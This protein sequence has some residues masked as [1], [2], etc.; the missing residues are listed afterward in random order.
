M[1]PNAAAIAA[2]LARSGAEPRTPVLTTPTPTDDAM[3]DDAMFSIDKRRW[4]RRSSRR[5]DDITRKK[6]LVRA[7]RDFKFRVLA[8]LELY[9]RAQ[10]G[11]P[12]L[13]GTALP[14]LGAMQTALAAGTPQASA[15]A[16]RIGGVLT[17][18]V[19]H[20]RDLP[21]DA[22]TEPDHRR[23]RCRPR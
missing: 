12:W 6:S 5:R 19:C 17:K 21:N 15:L 4:A 22:G 2:A 7:T 13:P 20:A 11:S 16:E 23:N 3:D 1:R 10:P 14:L 18:H 9:A 8:L